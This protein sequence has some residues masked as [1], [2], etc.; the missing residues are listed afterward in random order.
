MTQKEQTGLLAQEYQQLQTA[1]R[2]TGARMVTI[3]AWSVTFSAAGLGLAYSQ[4]APAFFLIASLSALV[5]WLIEG[6][7][8]SHQR[9]F[10]DRITQI[11]E[12]F[13]GGEQTVAFRIFK[14]RAA[15]LNR[16]SK[17]RRVTA[18]LLYPHVMLPHTVVA[19]AGLALFAIHVFEPPVLTALTPPPSAAPR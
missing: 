13:N 19:A 3:K 8:K 15:F 10:V 14:E 4:A 5:F 1:W 11:E 2:E 9:A 7:I 6:I 16:T 17:I 18:T 12:H